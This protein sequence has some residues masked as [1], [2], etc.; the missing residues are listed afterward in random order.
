MG[1]STK[2]KQVREKNLTVTKEERSFR[3]S[4]IHK[5]KEEAKRVKEERRSIKKD[6]ILVRK[7]LNKIAVMVRVESISKRD[8][9]IF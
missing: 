5:Q 2:K 1:K 8:L 7:V 3:K 4:L 9:N 6:K